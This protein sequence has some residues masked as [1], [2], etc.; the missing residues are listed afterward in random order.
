M[1][2]TTAEVFYVN[3]LEKANLFFGSKEVEKEEYAHVRNPYDKRVASLVAVCSAKDATDLLELAMCNRDKARRVPLSRR[4]RWIEDVAAKVLENKE[5]LARTITAETAK[6]IAFARAEVERCAETLKITAAAAYDM[7]GEL[8]NS[9]AAPSGTDALA[10][11]KR[12]PVGVAVAITPFN[13]PLNLV[14]HKLGPGL[15][16]GNVMV[17]KPAPEA[18]LTACKFAKLFIESEYATP[19]ALSV[20]HGDAE[21]GDALV[22]SEIPRKISFTGSVPVGKIITQRAGIKKLSLELG[23]NAATFVQDSADLKKA[24][25]R[26]AFGAFANAGQVCISLQRIYVDEGV[27]EAFA[28]LLAEETKKLNVGSCDD[29]ATFVSALINEEAALRARNWIDSAVSEG[30]RL[31]AGG[32][33]DGAVLTPA[34]L[35]DVTDD[36]TIVCEEV[37]APVVSLVKVS[38]FD[39]AIKK[40]NSSP[41]GLQF[42]V[43]TND[44]SLARRAIDE[45]DCGGVVVNDIPTLRFDIQPYGG[46]KYSGIGREGPKYAMEEF[47]EPKSVVIL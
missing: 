18:P 20:V 42:S 29:D 22:T 24:A 32:E 21:V 31:V 6:P 26:C 47:T 28:G 30:A 11:V 40:M 36:M 33:V 5:E 19:D 17:L 41:Y 39:E 44:L 4:I 2:A 10:F 38:G 16:T 45:L 37:F 9:D 23:G 14:A 27:Y 1:S 8:F 46:V 25:A 12:E 7:A 35:A 3:N 34:V 15:V 43:F 13:F